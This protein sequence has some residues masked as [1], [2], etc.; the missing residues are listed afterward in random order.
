MKHT[1]QF[2]KSIRIWEG[3]FRNYE[4]G[5]ILANK[6]I[7]QMQNESVIVSLLEVLIFLQPVF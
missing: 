2:S 3:F 6:R 5:S 4:Y 1:L 7:I